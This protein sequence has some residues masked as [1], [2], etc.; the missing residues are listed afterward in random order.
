MQVL[1]LGSNTAMRLFTKRMMNCP[2]SV[3]IG[4]EF[5]NLTVL[6]KRD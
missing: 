3:E 5:C 1:G 4:V 6:L 2:D